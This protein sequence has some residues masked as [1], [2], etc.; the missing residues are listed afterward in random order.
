VCAFFNSESCLSSSLDSHFTD[1]IFP[2]GF[3]FGLEFVSCSVFF[4]GQCAKPIF[5]VVFSGRFPSRSPILFA[6]L[7]SRSARFSLSHSKVRTL[8]KSA[9][10]GP[11]AF[12]L[13]CCPDRGFSLGFYAHPVSVPSGPHTGIDFTVARIDFL[14]SGAFLARLCFSSF[15]RW[16]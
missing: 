2:F 15:P 14:S 13:R 5:F 16:S 10:A 8:V 11:R 9:R 4:T 1:Q 12:L 6:A 7:T 3:G